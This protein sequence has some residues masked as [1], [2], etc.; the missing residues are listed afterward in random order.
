MGL[1]GGRAMEEGLNETPLE[2]R[3]EERYS[4]TVIAHIQ[5]A[6]AAFQKVYI[7]N[8]SASGFRASAEVMP[9]IGDSVDLKLANLNIFPGTVIWLRDDVFGVKLESPIDT[10]LLANR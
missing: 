10:D 5:I 3:S 9:K 7:R 4:R 8:F 6:G 1:I 2:D